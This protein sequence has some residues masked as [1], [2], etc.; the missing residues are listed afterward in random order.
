MV[1]RIEQ[2]PLPVDGAGQVG[3]G[4]G[5]IDRQPTNRFIARRPPPNSASGKTPPSG[6][7]PRSGR[8]PATP[9]NIIGSQADHQPP[10]P[11]PEPRSH[12][13]PA[14]A[15]IRPI[16]GRYYRDPTS[17]SSGRPVK[18]GRLSMASCSEYR[19]R[20]CIGRRNKW[21]RTVAATVTAMRNALVVLC[22]PLP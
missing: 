20:S 16:F 18:V 15:Q 3:H 21:R 9:T 12:P 1:G 17:A 11:Q 5:G 19:N 22:W 8:T 6:S 10:S 2:W 14:A 13:R 7:A 4:S